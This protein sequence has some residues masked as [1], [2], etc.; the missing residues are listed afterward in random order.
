MCKHDRGREG[1]R[2]G[3]EPR[4]ATPRKRAAAPMTSAKTAAAPGAAGSRQRGH[5]GLLQRLRTRIAREGPLTIA[6]YMQ[7]CLAD[8]SDGYWQ[9]PASIGAAGDFITAPEISQIFGE[10]IGLWCVVA[11]QGLGCPP[12]VRFVELG[13]GRATL[14]SDALRA[15]R[16]VP[17]FLAAA[18]VHLIEVSAPLR[19][20]QQ[21]VLT[22][23][24]ARPGETT[25][26]AGTHPALTWHA[27]IADLP[28]GPAIVVAN[29]YLDALPIRQLIF[30]GHGWR[31]RV[32][33]ADTE[34]GL[35]FALGASADAE[36][37]LTPTPPPGTVC[38][39]R[40]G[41]EALFAALARR[42]APLVA[43]CLDYGPAEEAFGDT[44]QGVA[45]H[46]YSDPL[47]APGAADLT[48]HVQ[49]AA[50][51]R[52]ARAAGFAVDGPIP[53]AE[54]LGRLGITERAARLMAANPQ[55]AA[56]IEAG[57]ARLM[58]PTGM[59]GLI[60]VLAVRSAHLPP[61]PAF[62]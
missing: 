38:E 12:C 30:S 61:L 24:D 56:E 2:L 7:A 3:E 46:T 11:W 49:F 21:R 23:A 42:A 32:V 59:G 14:L 53:Q 20:V 28:P 5:P 4:P 1:P 47:A 22:A 16:T 18:S 37:R 35:R 9:K 17:A 34:G 48:A 36:H 41:E 26:Y 13:P 45:A 57:V 40:P 39:L 25:A 60:K 10:L 62:G 54:F 33:V 8:P 58:S 29:E 55:R 19:A 43:L 31:E 15:A 44:L 51:R 27:T 6:E 50:V 52:K